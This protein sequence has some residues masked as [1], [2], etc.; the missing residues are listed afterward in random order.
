MSYISVISKND[1]RVQYMYI[2][3]ILIENFHGMKRK[4]TFTFH[5]YIQLLNR[6]SMELVTSIVFDIK[7]T[8]RVILFHEDSC[9]YTC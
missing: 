7:C 1:F 9:T 4:E 5:C 2:I 6:K 3:P 8:R